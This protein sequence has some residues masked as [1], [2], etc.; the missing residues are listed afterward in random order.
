MQR[1]ER[2]NSGN[3]LSS[4]SKEYIAAFPRLSPS[5]FPQKLWSDNERE[6]EKWKRGDQQSVYRRDVKVARKPISWTGARNNQVIL[7]F[8]NWLFLHLF[9]S[10]FFLADTMNDSGIEFFPILRSLDLRACSEN[11]KIHC[12]SFKLEEK[13][14]EKKKEKRNKLCVMARFFLR[15]KIAILSLALVVESVPRAMY[16]R[17][18]CMY[19]RKRN[20]INSP[21]GASRRYNLS[22]RLRYVSL[23]Y[24]PGLFLWETSFFLRLL[25]A[26]CHRLRDSPKVKTILSPIDRNIRGEH[27][28]P[29]V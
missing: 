26:C 4:R 28:I 27:Q 24:R 23:S 11:V 17:C 29:I 25:S 19:A 15:S 6:R 5:R 9:F 22:C 14:R 20:S 8:M 2:G 13:E 1:D 12:R 21:L 3:Q 7:S 18:P 10:Y 16:S